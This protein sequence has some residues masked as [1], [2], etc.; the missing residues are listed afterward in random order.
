LEQALN[1]KIIEYAKRVIELCHSSKEQLKNFFNFYWVAQEYKG[2]DTHLEQYKQLEKLLGAVKNTRKFNNF[3]EEPGRKCALNGEYNVKFYRKSE[4]EKNRSKE[5]LVKSKIFNENLLLVEKDDTNTISLR[6]LAEGEGLSAISFLKRVYRKDEIES[7]PSTARVALLDMLDKIYENNDILDA[8][9]NFIKYFKISSQEKWL[10]EIITNC[11]GLNIN[12]NNAVEFND[13]YFYQENILK[14]RFKDV[15]TFKDIKSAQRELSKKLKDKK[16]PLTKY[17]A[18]IQFDGDNMGKWLS[19]KYVNAGK[20]YHKFLSEKLSK[21][22]E[23]AKKILQEPKGKTVYAGG[24]DFLGLVNLHHLF[25]VII[26]LRKE[27]EDLV[28]KPIQEKY[29]NNF[30]ERKDLTFSAGVSIAHYKTPLSIALNA[31]RE[32]QDKA[33]KIIEDKNAVALTVLKHSGETEETILKFGDNE[34][35]NINILKAIIDN[36]A[37]EKF[38]TS[39]ITN[40]NREFILHIDEEGKTELDKTIIETELSRLLTRSA[41]E[42]ISK[43]Q[44][45]EM[46]ENLLSLYY[47]KELKNYLSLLN[48]IDFIIRKSH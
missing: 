9:C 17:Y 6:Q 2:E 19:G 1:E 5:Q 45:E 8:F 4:K 27:F 7:F 23:E 21:F 24:D 30:K 3:T 42:D 10:F 13:Q 35:K 26:K 20:E 36:L 15:Q 37:T 40:F 46:K 18:I 16:I 39:F 44:I 29:H 33:K 22:S 34:A 41:R 14:E 38:S 32:M 31:A 11:N 12:F 28:N 48:I 43:A 47:N 25:E